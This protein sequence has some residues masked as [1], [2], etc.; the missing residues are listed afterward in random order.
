MPGLLQHRAD[1][2]TLPTPVA[3][4]GSSNL[5]DVDLWLPS[6]VAPN[7][8]VLVCQEGLAKM[9]DQLCTAQCQDALNAVRN[10]LKIKTR[11]IAFKNRNVRGQRQGT[12]SRAV[13]D[14]VHERARVAAG[15]Y[16]AAWAAK[17]KL[18][19]PGKWEETLK[20]LTDGDIHGYQDANR[21]KPRQPRRGITEDGVAEPAPT[22]N[23]D[24]GPEEPDNLL[25]AEARTRRDGTG[26][27]RRILSWIWLVAGGETGEE[28]SNEILRVEWAKSRARAQ[29]ATE[30]VYKLKEEMRRVLETLRWEESDWKHHVGLRS[31]VTSDLAEGINALSLTQASIKNDLANQF[32]RLWKS[33]LEDTSDSLD[34]S[35]HDADADANAD[36]D[37]EDGDE[38]DEVSD[39]D[40]LDG[41]LETRRPA[42]TGGDDDDDEGLLATNITR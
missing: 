41:L 31:G 42:D 12:R 14:R 39:S 11:M 27:T 18:V 8:R 26:E 23:P 22:L 16:R 17:V 7:S 20:V 35:S 19:G 29:C 10:I 6:H 24:I 4:G 13:I 5:E 40:D 2:A 21:L 37:D 25:F 36:D 33:P 15:K 28:G 38:D 1:L 32:R 9:E 34:T 3:N 30:E